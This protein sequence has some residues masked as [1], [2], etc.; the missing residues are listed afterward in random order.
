[1]YYPVLCMFIT[2]ISCPVPP[3]SIPPTHSSCATVYIP[4]QPFYVDL[5]NERTQW[6]HPF[7]NTGASVRGWHLKEENKRGTTNH[8]E[9][10]IVYE[11]ESGLQNGT[12]M[13][14]DS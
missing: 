1:M 14:P 11:A 13:D 9:G 7:D 3:H 4:F 5:E 10:G 12:L 8:I 2:N 6:R